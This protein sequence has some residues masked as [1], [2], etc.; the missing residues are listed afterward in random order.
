MEILCVFF[1]SSLLHFV[2][3]LG[4]MDNKTLLITTDT[5]SVCSIRFWDNLTCVSWYM[6][7]CVCVFA[8]CVIYNRIDAVCSTYT[9]QT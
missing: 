3:K 5:L 6:C 4:Y 9:V 8:I 1:S 2:A 7:A